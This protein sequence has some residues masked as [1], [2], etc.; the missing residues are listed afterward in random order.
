MHIQLESVEQFSVQAYD[1]SQLRINGQDYQKSLLVSPGFLAD[2]FGVTDLDSLNLDLLAPYLDTPP[3]V[4]II[5]HS[6]TGQFPTMA[7]ISQ[8][9]KRGI[10]VESMSLGAA[11]RTYNILLSEGRRVWGIFLLP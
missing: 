2:D 9:S 8:L 1:D 5:G 7:L 3:E 10:G 6:Q 11:C 4:I